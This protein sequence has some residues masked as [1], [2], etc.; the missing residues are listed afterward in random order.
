MKAAAVKEMRA[1]ERPRVPPAWLLVAAGWLVPGAAYLLLRRYLQAALF[2]CAVWAAFGVGF[3]L[4]GGLA[5]PHATDLAG[6]D[7]LTALL[8]RGGAAAQTLAGGPYLLAHLLGHATPFLDGRLREY[9]TTLFLFAGLLNTLAIFT[10][11][12]VE[13]EQTQ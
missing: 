10:A 13:K 8:L 5:W 2:A 1:G 12:G 11:T 7:G 3:A 6:L 9:G 4:H